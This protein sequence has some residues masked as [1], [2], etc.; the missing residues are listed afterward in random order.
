M[1]IKN[2][3]M[4]LILTIVLLIIGSV[5]CT[6]TPAQEVPTQEVQE[7]I[8][9]TVSSEPI[10]V[11]VITEI[12][13]TSAAVGEGAQNGI[14]LYLQQVNE[15]GGVLGREVVAVFADDNSTQPGAV[16]AFNKLVLEDNVDVILGPLFSTHCL[17][18]KPRAEELGFPWL[19]MGLNHRI[20]TEDNPKWTFQGRTTDSI[21][22]LLVLDFLEEQGKS[23]PAILYV[24]DD[25]GIDGRDKF[26]S[27][28]EKRGMNLASAEALQSGDKDFTAQI[29]SIKQ[30]GAD[31][32][33][34]W[35]HVDEAGLVLRQLDE[36]GVNIEE[37]P[38]IGNSSFLG[39]GVVEVAGDAAKG[40]Y[41]VSGT[42]PSMQNP[43]WSEKFKETYGSDPDFLAAD[44]VDGFATI[45]RAVELAG[46]TDAESIRQGFLSIKDWKGPFDFSHTFG[47]PETPQIGVY[48]ALIVRLDDSLKPEFVSQVER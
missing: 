33:I 38:F 6:P 24:G 46:S 42:E 22:P 25:F 23:N 32:I 17:A 27:E 40:T 41:I 7:T 19:A 28:I 45:L 26:Q 35:L 2:R 30:S 9:P 4:L 11:G 43:Q 36:Q 34:G 18:I 10:K 47:K 29:L 31:S 5:R 13:G 1:F 37:V 3:N 21:L 14:N 15:S 8:E 48:S 12:T 20:G 39:S 44:P 16:N